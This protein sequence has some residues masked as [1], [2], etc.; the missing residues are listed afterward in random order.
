MAAVRPAF[1]DNFQA[2]VQN[3][4]LGGIQEIAPKDA[5]ID[6]VELS[7]FRI[8]AGVAALALSA[9]AYNYSYTKSA[10]AGV[11]VA[12]VAFYLRNVTT[13]VDSPELAAQ[14]KAI[15][16]ATAGIVEGLT[17]LTTAKQTTVKASLDGQDFSGAYVLQ[18]ARTALDD[19]VNA[20]DDAN[21][22]YTDDQ[23]AQAYRQVLPTAKEFLTIG[24]RTYPEAT[25]PKLLLDRLVEIHVAADIF[26]NGYVKPLAEKPGD[27]K[28]YLNL[29]LNGAELVVQ[30][31]TDPSALKA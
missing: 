27:Y 3:P 10:I 1:L 30:P 26:V 31:W 17:A 28:G 12:L 4:T 5:K 11:G 20:Y 24:V 22:R 6:K 18:S 25:T 13:T 9:L 29:T 16:D 23:S 15:N 14:N 7:Y 8:A 21:G 19:F 2:L